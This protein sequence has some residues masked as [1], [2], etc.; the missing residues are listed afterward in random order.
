MSV[1][2][3]TRADALAWEVKQILA[4]RSGRALVLM[5]DLNVRREEVAPLCEEHGLRAM[6][7]GAATWNARVNKFYEDQQNRR[8]TQEFDR[9]LN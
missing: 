3:K 4:K 1:A 8:D 5:G 9:I 7:L 2:S 6:A